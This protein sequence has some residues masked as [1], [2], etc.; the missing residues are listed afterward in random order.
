MQET[1]DKLPRFVL[2]YLDVYIVIKIFIR[3]VNAGRLYT[4]YGYMSKLE[5]SIFKS[6][7]L[8]IIRAVET[9]SIRPISN[10]VNSLL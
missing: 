5:E 8:S 10:V 4:R 1:A 9:S 7:S 2:M 6:R 3:H